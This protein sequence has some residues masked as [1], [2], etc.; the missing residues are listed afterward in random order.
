MRSKFKGSVKTPFFLLS[1]KEKTMETTI[2]NNE[3]Y[4]MLT[5]QYLEDG[6]KILGKEIEG[7]FTKVFV[8]E[9][10]LNKKITPKYH[11]VKDIYTKK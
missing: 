9:T 11:I 6:D 3:K 2:I 4:V 7:R 10:E 5:N 8:L 1:L